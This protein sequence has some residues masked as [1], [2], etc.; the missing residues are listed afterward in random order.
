MKVTKYKAKENFSIGEYLI[1][2]DDNF[3]ISESYNNICN[4]NT[5]R[6]RIWDTNGKCL[7][8]QY[9]SE[10]NKISKV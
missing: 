6:V 3:Y 5:D 2:T 1:K 10:F 9:C 8:D 7:G 4:T